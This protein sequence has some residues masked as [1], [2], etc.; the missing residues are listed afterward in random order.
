MDDIENR[1]LRCKDGMA[2]PQEIFNGKRNIAVYI[3]L[4]QQTV[5]LSTSISILQWNIY[6]KYINFA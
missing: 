3:Q 5:Q 2:T 6:R 4:R 1:V